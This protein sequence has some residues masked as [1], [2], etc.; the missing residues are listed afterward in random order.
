MKNMQEYFS[1]FEGRE[2]YIAANT[3][4]WGLAFVD[5][6]GWHELDSSVKQFDWVIGFYDKFIKPL[7]ENTLLTIY[8]C[9]RPKQS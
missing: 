4:F 2:H 1:N 8:E 9:V 6:S 3:A 7:P 5:D